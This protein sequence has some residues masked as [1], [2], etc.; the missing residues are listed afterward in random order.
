MPAPAAYAPA[1]PIAEAPG[2][3]WYVRPPGG[4]QY[5][6][7]RGDVMRKWVSEGRVSTDSLVWREGWTDWRNAGQLF[8]NLATTGGG[9]AGPIAAPITTRTGSATSRRPARQKGGAGMA[10]AFLAI[11]AVACVALVAVLIYVLTKQ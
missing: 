10:I 8:P 6:P 1:D 2:A 7:A 9:S 11:L 5:G 4:G 3:T